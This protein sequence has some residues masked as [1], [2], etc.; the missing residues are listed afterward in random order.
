MLVNKILPFLAAEIFSLHREKNV[1]YHD[2]AVL[3]KDRYMAKEVVDYL[4]VHGIPAASKQGALITESI[5]YFAL[6]EMLA[7]VCFP[8]DLSK[9]KA[10]LGGPLIGWDQRQLER[11]SDNPELLQAKA[12]MHSL[13]NI[14]LEKGF[15]AFFQ[16]LQDEILGRV[17]QSLYLDLRKLA[18]LCIEEAMAR[19][20]QGAGFLDFLTELG[21]ESHREDPRLKTATQEEKGSVAVM[22]IHVS[23]GLEFDTVFA[24]GTAARHKP[25]ELIAVDQEMRPYCPEDPD[26]R[27]SFEEQDAENASTLRGPN[28]RKKTALRPAF[29]R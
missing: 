23:K 9:V 14:L 3:I 4:K 22:T 15:G 19:D 2:I 10:A 18:E 29:D 6:K 13:R 27:R 8:S 7:A 5:A 24:L 28:T 25:S 17:D 1:A 12:Q 20:V 26:C 11:G 21:I 16:T